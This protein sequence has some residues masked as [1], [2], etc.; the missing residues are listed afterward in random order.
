MINV[1]VMILTAGIS[2]GLIQGKISS[3]ETAQATMSQVIASQAIRI[4]GF[5]KEQ[6]R[7]TRLEVNLQNIAT[8]LQEIRKD[9]REGRH[10]PPPKK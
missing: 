2:Y 8:L 3:L 6:D 4:D 5:V 7:V 1:F 9:L 10:A